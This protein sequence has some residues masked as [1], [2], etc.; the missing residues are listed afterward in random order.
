LGRESRKITDE[1]LSGI[2]QIS[3][4]TGLKKSDVSRMP[5]KK[6][7][8]AYYAEKEINHYHMAKPLIGIVESGIFD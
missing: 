5:I 2:E 4:L 3:Q 8:E 7:I 1:Y 6:F